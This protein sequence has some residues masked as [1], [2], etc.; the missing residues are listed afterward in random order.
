MRPAQITG[1]AKDGPNPVEGARVHA[2]TLGGERRSDVTGPLGRF[3]LGD[4]PLGIQVI[5]TVEP[6]IDRGGLLPPPP[7]TVTTPISNVTLNFGTPNKVVI[8][9]VKTNTGISV[10]H[11]L[12]EAHRMD[13]LG[14][15]SA[16]TDANGLYSA[17]P[18]ARRV[19][20]RCASDHDDR[21]AQLDRSES[22]A[23]GAVR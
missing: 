15:D 23:F 5:L 22:A 14:R 11:A 4:L 1:V 16:E 6:P 13:A 2:I 8:G 21:A 9:S 3:A 12:I 18:D 17:A 20:D 10:T 7:M 19:V